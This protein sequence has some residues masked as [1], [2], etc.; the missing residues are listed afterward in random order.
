MISV[1]SNGV[2]N[3]IVWTL[4]PIDGNANKAVVAGIVRAYD[5]TAFDPTNNTDDTRKLK[6]LWDSTR[7]GVTFNFSKFCPP[8]VADGK[9][10]VPTYSGRVDVYA[11]KP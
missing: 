3:G 10:Y 2:N 9:L 7:A 6:L 4:A 11:L 5:A 1:S 8:V